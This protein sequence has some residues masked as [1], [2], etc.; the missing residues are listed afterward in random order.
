MCIVQCKACTDIL[1]A[2]ESVD[3][4]VKYVYQAEVDMSNNLYV[5]YILWG[6]E[7]Q[8]YWNWNI[9]LSELENFEESYSLDVC[10]FQV[11]P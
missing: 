3:G 9:I 11:L 2:V 1:Q 10:T 7:P 4:Y 8:R 5:N 6:K